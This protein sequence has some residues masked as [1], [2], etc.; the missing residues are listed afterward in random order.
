MFPT[1]YGTQRKNSTREN[2]P[3]VQ[4][5]EYLSYIVAS[6]GSCGINL[7]RLGWEANGFIK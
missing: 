7:E 3:M 2:L 6:E 1:T 5:F 4:F